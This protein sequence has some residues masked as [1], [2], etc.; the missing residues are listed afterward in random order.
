MKKVIFVR[1]GK[2]EDSGS[3]RN[4]FQ[5][6][7]TPRGKEISARMADKLA[8][9]EKGDM[10]IITSPAFRALETAVI[11]AT[12]LNISCDDIRMRETIYGSFTADRLFHL[13]NEIADTVHTVV[14]FGH[15]PSFTLVVNHLLGTDS[16]FMP[17]SGVACIEFNTDRWASVPKAGSKLSYFLNP[18]G[19]DD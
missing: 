19:T 10:V 6:S 8:A 16:R 18:D 3:A 11:F 12:G 1:H 5:R 2:A 7:L 4:D 9:R 15:N 14:L 17:K 13:L